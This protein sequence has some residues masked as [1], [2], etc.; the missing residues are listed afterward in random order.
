MSYDL[1]VWDG[2]RSAS[3][4]EGEETFDRLCTEFIDGALEPTP[5]SPRIAAYVDALIERYP[6][7]LDADGARYDA[8][9]ERLSRCAEV[10]A[11]RAS[12]HGRPGQPR[13][14]LVLISRR[15]SRPV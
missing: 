13:G 7:G 15:S 14:V 5:P 11:F 8:A 10:N 2:P 4:E 1:A 9:F 3:H 6:D 12:A